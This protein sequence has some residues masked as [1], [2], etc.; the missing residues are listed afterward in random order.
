MSETIYPKGILTFAR[1]EN[2]RQFVLGSAVITIDDLIEWSQGEGSQYLSE[3]KGKKQI[4]LNILQSKDGS[5]V[6]FTVDT[7]KP[8]KKSNHEPQANNAEEMDLPF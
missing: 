4:R 2:Q 5:R 3:Y 6:N 1:K 7:W 8:E